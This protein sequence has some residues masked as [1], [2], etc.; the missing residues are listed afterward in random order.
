MTTSLVLPT[1]QLGD[2]RFSTSPLCRALTHPI[3]LV[4]GCGSVE[5]RPQ[6]RYRIL[7]M[8]PGATKRSVTFLGEL[9]SGSLR[10]ADQTRGHGEGVR[11]EFGE[12]NVSGVSKFSFDEPCV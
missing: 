2:D 1:T 4:R 11:C 6:T 3:T 10:G 9:P 12:L 8:T 5:C 7:G